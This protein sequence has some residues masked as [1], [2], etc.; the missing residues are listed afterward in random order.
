MKLFVKIPIASLGLL[1][2][3]N[4]CTQINKKTNAH[5]IEN[6]STSIWIESSKNNTIPLDKRKQ[7]L[8]KAEKMIASKPE[9]KSNAKILGDVAFRFAKLKDTIYFKKIND[10]VLKLGTK[11]QDSSIIAKAYWSYAEF[12]IYQEIF[13]KAYSNYNIAYGYFNGIQKHHEAG[14]MLFAMGWIKWKYNDFTDS[15]NLVFQAIKKYKLVNNSKRLRGAYNHLGIMNLDMKEYDKAIFYLNK[16]LEYIPRLKNN[17]DYYETYYNNL[18]YTYLLMKKYKLAIEYFDKALSYYTENDIYTINYAN[19]LG[20]RA[21]CLLS[22]EDTTGLKKDFFKV[23][24]IRDS[25]NYIGGISPSKMLISTYYAYAK[26][27]AKALSYAYEANTLAGKIKDGT[28]YL[29]SL[30]LLSIFDSKN[31]KKYLDRYIYYNDSLIKIERK[32]QNKFT[33]IAFETDEYIQ[34]TKR[35]SIQKV[36]IMI[37]G[38]GVLLILSLL[39]F[40]RIQ[41]V[42]TEKLLLETE[43]QKANEELYLLTIQQQTALEKEKAEER[44]RISQELHDG[45][46]GNLFGTRVGLGFIEVKGGKEQQF[47]QETYLVKLQEIEKEIREVSHK[48]NSDF[49][50]SKVSFKSIIEQLLKN[51]SI[52]GGFDFE[53]NT[54]KNLSWESMNEIIKVNVYRIVQESLQ[55]IIKHA[56]AKQVLLDFSIKNKSFIFTLKDDG[57]GFDVKKHKKGIGL[58]NIKSRVQKLK[59]KLQI[60]S[61]KNEG[62]TIHITIP[63]L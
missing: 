63:I 3:L 9:S 55:N 23:L 15:E 45:I 34:E 37:T 36:W 31:A 44:N 60:I 41:K 46:L 39:Y 21:S 25:I 24:H 54:D 11:Y 6:D 20:N 5:K 53:I 13:D 10:K 19:V 18:G 1:L 62:T 29:G 47:K 2:V 30:K 16:S 28:N 58:R 35:L 51:K 59:G 61:K 48:L 49:S 52:L 14:R 7:D 56:K 27:T 26:D 40:L 4:S 50:N 57:L 22:L 38:I 33:R 42:K 12:Y 8:L 32:A 43:Q 17:E